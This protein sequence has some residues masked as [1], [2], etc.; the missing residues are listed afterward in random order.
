MNM[1]PAVYA[2]HPI[3]VS[4]ANNRGT[5][6]HVPNTNTVVAPSGPYNCSQ[7]HNPHG[8]EGFGKLLRASYDTSEYVQYSS[9][10]NPYNACWSCHDAQKIVNDTTFFKKHKM[11]IIDKKS[12][13]SA[14]HDSPHGVP[15]TE[16]ARFDGMYVTKSNSSNSGPSFTDNGNNRG[17][18][19][20]TCHGQDHKA[21]S[22]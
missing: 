20:L 19:T 18:C 2:M 14:C 4:L 10:V 17:S 9:A 1:D 5:Y 15:Y 8:G 16:M 3:V 13:C 11:H 21:A 6:N 12:P 22:Y 7:C